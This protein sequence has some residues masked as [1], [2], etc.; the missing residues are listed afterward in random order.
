MNEKI[1][2][3]ISKYIGDYKLIGPGDTVIAGVSGGADSMCMLLILEELSEKQDF[4]VIVAH[5]NHGIRGKDAE[6]DAEFVKK[7]CEKNKIQFELSCKDIPALAKETGTTCEEAGRNFRYKFFSELCEKYGARSIAVA[8]NSGDNAETV[9][10]NIFRGSGIGG[11]KGILPVRTIRSA[12]GELKIIRPVLVLSREEI[13]GYLRERGQGYCTDATNNE[14]AYTRNRIRNVILP[15]ARKGINSNVTGHLENLSRQAAEVFDFI[16]QET[17]RYS[18]IISETAGP[19]KTGKLVKVDCTVLK[20]LHPVLKKSILRHAFE[21]AAGRLK[22]VEEVHIEDMLRLSENTSGKKISLPY[23]IVAVKEY[24]DILLTKENIPQK[25]DITV[26]LTIV[27]RDTLPAQ[28]PNEDDV[29]WFDLEKITNATELRTM[30]EG[31]YLVI[32]KDAHKK[33]LKR[34]MID[35]KIPLHE[36]ED[37]LLLTEGSHVLWVVGYR[38]DDSCLVSGSTQKVLIAKKIHL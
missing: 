32:G 2:N 22:D 25:K 30:R 34:F 8:H 14:D 21:R 20:S 33:S 35:S 38:R 27:D 15:E 13:E 36:R 24:D 18:Y 1:L 4:K 28:I 37:I 16:E 26:E 23:G 6:K 10:F 3:K 11:L 9:L 17:D 7:Y 12:F 31:D 29:K 19:D 5:V